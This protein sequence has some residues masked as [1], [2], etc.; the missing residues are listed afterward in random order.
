MIGT[1][2]FKFK[3]RHHSIKASPKNVRNTEIN[4]T[5]AI[6]SASFGAC[7][8]TCLTI[9]KSVW[10]KIFE[11]KIKKKKLRIRGENCGRICLSNNIRN[12][13]TIVTRMICISYTEM[14]SHSKKV[15]I[16]SKKKRRKRNISTVIYRYPN[17]NK[18][19]ENSFFPVCSKKRCNNARINPIPAT[20]ITSINSDLSPPLSIHRMQKRA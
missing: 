11:S 18:K 3:L 1:N 16:S 4:S 13:I 19:N 10:N 7:S 9:G 20:R 5:R 12:I 6:G 15:V 8:S 14:V 2:V 17:T